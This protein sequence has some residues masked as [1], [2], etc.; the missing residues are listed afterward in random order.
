MKSWLFSRAVLALFA[1]FVPCAWA[2]DASIDQLLEKLPPPEK[3][4][5]PPVATGL[6]TTDP[7][8]KDPLAKEMALALQSRDFPRAASLAHQLLVRYPQSAGALCMNATAAT[9]L[10][11]FAEAGFSLRKAITLQPDLAIAHFMLGNLEVA[12]QHYEASLPHFQ[13]AAELEPKNPIALVFL[14]ECY[15]KI[16]RRNEGIDYAKRATTAVPGFV[17]GWLQLARVEKSV[18]HMAETISALKHALDASPDNVQLLVLVGSS[19][20]SQNRSAEALPL[21]RHA[22]EVAPNE[23]LVQANLGLA[24]QN[25]KQH[26]EAVKAFERA[27]EIMPNDRAGWE[28]LAEEY[29]ATEQSAKAKRATERAQSLPAVKKS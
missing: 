7:A 23:F 21:L 28:H 22:A 2:Q 11:Q 1:I 19:Y 4:A 15:A 18:G 5:P 8:P 13:K 20:I 26:Q 9:A 3:F 24:Y 10:G 12:Q 25:Q 29:R 14:S 27:T 6:S 16:G 17:G